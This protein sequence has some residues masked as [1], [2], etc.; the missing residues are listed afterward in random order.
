MTS[1]SS[2][3]YI[4]YFVSNHYKYEIIQFF[5]FLSFGEGWGEVILNGITVLEDLG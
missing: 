3:T 2:V 5:S 4:T 1:N